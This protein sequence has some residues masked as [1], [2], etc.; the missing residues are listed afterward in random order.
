MA[1]FDEFKGCRLLD[2]NTKEIF[3]KRNVKFEEDALHAPLDEPVT[4][5]PLPLIDEY[6]VSVSL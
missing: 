2:I 4:K 3:T 6:V 5:L 1:Y